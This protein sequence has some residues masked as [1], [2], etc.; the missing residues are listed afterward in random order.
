MTESQST[1]LWLGALR[2]YMGRMT[3]AVSEFCDMLIAEWPNLPEPTRNLIQRDLMQEINIDNQDRA[4]ERDTGK[5]RYYKRLGHDCDRAA[6]DRVA[7]LWR[8][9]YR[10]QALEISDANV[11]GWGNTMMDAANTLQRYVDEDV[12]AG[13]EMVNRKMANTIKDNAPTCHMR[14]MMLEESDSV[15]GHYDQ[16]WECSVCGHTKVL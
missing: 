9:K 11:P 1:T 12:F 3:Y 10:T 15:D 7:K 4:E 16:W 2:Y 14:K 6:W 5:P 8:D 13:M